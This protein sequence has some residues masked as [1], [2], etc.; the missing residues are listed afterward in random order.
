LLAPIEFPGTIQHGKVSVDSQ[1]AAIVGLGFSL[2]FKLTAGTFS[3]SFTMT[4][5]VSDLAD[6]KVKMIGGVAGDV[7]FLPFGL[8]KQ[9]P[10]VRGSFHVK[11]TG[12]T[13][14]VE[15]TPR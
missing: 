6:E 8:D 3:G 13:G 1:D 5:A 15:I 2:K 14:R 4:P 11:S 7:G 10:R 12:R 9:N